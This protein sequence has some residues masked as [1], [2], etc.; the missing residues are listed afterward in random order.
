MDK[1]E[2]GMDDVSQSS[3]SKSFGALILACFCRG[4]VDRVSGNITLI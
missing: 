4:H 1:T 2:L 3:Q